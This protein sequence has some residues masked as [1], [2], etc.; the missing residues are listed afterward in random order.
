MAKLLRAGVRRYTK[1]IVFYIILLATVICAVLC[2]S[3][4]RKLYLEDTYIIAE[5]FAM[6]ILITWLVG[7]EFDEGV[8]RNKIIAGHSKLSVF[9]S[10]LI[11]GVGS[12]VFLFLVFSS[13]FAAFNSY[14][15]FAV[16][17]NVLIRIF[18]GCLFANITLVAFMV[19]FSCLIPHRA[20][21]AIVNIVLIF[22]LYLSSYSIDNILNGKE[23][24]LE[25]DYTYETRIDE[26]G[27][28]YLVSEEI[29]GSEHFIKNPQYIG[30]WRRTT[31]S[32]I[33]K[34]MPL[35]HIV[36]NTYLVYNCFG[37][38]YYN[39]FPDGDLTY[40]TSPDTQFSITVEDNRILSERLIYMPILFLVISVAG[41]SV[42]RR[43]NF[44]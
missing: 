18:F 11:L 41:Y 8:F 30:G 32:W 43:K 22:A 9:L 19:L 4:A 14:I 3:Y 42:F 38:D 34:F 20:I 40:E 27:N 36:S 12:C 37:Y 2:G 5:F 28:T 15:F 33:Y 10:E 35:A 6:A 31:L 29:P 26:N 16:P 39:I 13:I 1:S 44:K 7:R 17:A 25:Y 21:I 23:Y 24:W